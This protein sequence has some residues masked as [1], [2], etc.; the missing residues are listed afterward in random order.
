[1]CTIEFY[2]K[3]LRQTASA[4]SST[5]GELPDCSMRSLARSA[6]NRIGCSK[7]F[8]TSRHFETPHSPFR[9]TVTKISTLPLKEREV[10]FMDDLYIASNFDLRNGTRVSFLSYWICYCQLLATLL[11][12]LHGL[13][14]KQKGTAQPTT[15]QSLSYCFL[16]KQKKRKSRKKT[17]GPG[18]YSID[19]ETEVEKG[20]KPN[21]TV[22]EREAT[23]DQ[24]SHLPRFAERRGHTHPEAWE[25]CCTASLLHQMQGFCVLHS[26]LIM[27]VD[28]QKN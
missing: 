6:Q 1:M 9:Q 26:A 20:K 28:S 12:R 22:P 3:P 10:F 5:A 8:V 13:R 21:A 23:R 17:R 11:E 2:W 4:H 27:L 24:R 15:I 7:T 14:H 25:C 16:C 19:V 18:L